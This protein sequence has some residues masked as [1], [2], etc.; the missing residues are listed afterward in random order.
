MKKT[1]KLFY[2]FQGDAAGLRDVLIKHFKE[3]SETAEREGGDGQDY[4]TG[5]NRGRV[6]AYRDAA[7]FLK[8]LVIN[9]NEFPEEPT[10]NEA[11]KP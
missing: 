8:K 11:D 4:A 3:E 7:I 1:A 6:V 2:A 5:L 9:G 10:I